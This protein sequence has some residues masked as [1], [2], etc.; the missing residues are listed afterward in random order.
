MS[1]IRPPLMLAL[2]TPTTRLPCLKTRPAWPLTDCSVAATG[3]TLEK[4]RMSRR[5]AC[6]TPRTG[7]GDTRTFPPPSMITVMSG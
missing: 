4:T 3:G 7:D 1:K 5:A 2:S 6:S